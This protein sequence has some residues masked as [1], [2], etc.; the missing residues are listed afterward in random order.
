MEARAGT[1]C[2]SEGRDVKLLSYQGLSLPYALGELCPVGVTMVTRYNLMRLE[3]SH[4]GTPALPGAEWTV[5]Y[6]WHS[7]WIL[8][9][10]LLNALY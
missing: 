8:M 5:S 3:V 2:Q 6:K 9:R 10:M 7:V 1:P 4:L